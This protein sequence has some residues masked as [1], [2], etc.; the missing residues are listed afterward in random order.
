MNR[1]LTAVLAASLVALA[2]DAAQAATPSA[3]VAQ[4]IRSGFFA[5][6]NL[7]GFFTATG[8]N[9]KG[10]KGVSN[11]QAYLQLGV[12]YDVAKFLAVGVHF[13]IGSSANSCFATSVKGTGAC[14]FGTTNPAT[15]PDNFTMS[16]LGAEGVF[17][18]AVG[19]RLFLRP[20]IDVGWTFLEPAP[21]VD[22]DGKE[23]GGGAYVGLGF[24]IEYATHMDHFSI[25]LDVGGKLIIGPNIPAFAFYP[26]IK[27][28]F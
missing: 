3:G 26:M 14:V 11:A 27:Y 15:A 22:K 10:N 21:V 16:M 25:G 12:G 24:G 7:G 9:S 23:V 8:A 17:K 28:T 19:E 4:E 18:V 2:P 13:G 20:R 1:A 5:D 6:V